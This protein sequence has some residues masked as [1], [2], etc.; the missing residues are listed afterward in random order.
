MLGD[1]SKVRIQRVIEDGRSEKAAGGGDESRRRSLGF[2]SGN[3]AVFKDAARGLDVGIWIGVD[4]Y[5]IQFSLIRFRGVEELLPERGKMEISVGEEEKS[6]F[7]FS[8][9]GTQ[10]GDRS[11]WVN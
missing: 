4:V 5:I 11:R 10:P 3:K 9:G 7:G 2:F 6:D 1:E 8:V